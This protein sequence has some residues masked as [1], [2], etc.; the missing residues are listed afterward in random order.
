MIRMMNAKVEDVLPSLKDRDFRCAF[1]DPP[2]NIGLPYNTFRDHQDDYSTWLAIIVKEL[3]RVCDVGWLSFNAR[4]TF[5]MGSIVNEILTRNQALRAKPM[6]QVFTFGQ[7]NHNDLGNNH[8][9][10]VRFM[11]DGVQLYPDAVRV[12]SWRQLHG[13]NR[14]DPRGRVPGDVFDFPRVTGNSRQRRRWHPTQ[15]N[16]GLVERCLKMSCVPGDKVL[17]LFSGTGTTLRVCRQ[18]NLDCLSVEYDSLYCQ[19]IADENGLKQIS[20]KEWRY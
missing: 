6:V 10:I 1:G 9:P 18:L 12:P 8:R 2:D 20:E 3:V 13:D 17:D 16:E 7:H 14:A 5:S 19:K 15:L 4:H 11:W